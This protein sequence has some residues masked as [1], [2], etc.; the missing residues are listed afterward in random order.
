MGIWSLSSHQQIAD[1]PQLV[2]VV[3]K[4]ERKR[5]ES[6]RRG[7]L[8]RERVNVRGGQSERDEVAKMLRRERREMWARV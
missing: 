3:R 4:K 7:E 5:D 6:K 1:K 2:A 8:A